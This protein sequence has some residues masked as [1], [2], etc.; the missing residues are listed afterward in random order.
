LFFS[1]KD[2][3]P[4]KFLNTKKGDEKELQGLK[5]L[6]TVTNVSSS[7][8]EKKTDAKPEIKASEGPKKFISKKKDDKEGDAAR[9][10]ADVF[11]L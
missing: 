4:K 1:K 3:G 7:V 8:V 6:D 10:L 11:Y 2:S 9:S 5:P